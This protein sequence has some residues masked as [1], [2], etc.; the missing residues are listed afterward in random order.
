MVVDFQRKVGPL[1]S[2]GGDGCLWSLVWK[3]IRENPCA[4]FVVEFEVT[5]W[6]MFQFCNVC[7]FFCLN[8]LNLSSIVTLKMEGCNPFRRYVYQPG[9]NWC[10]PRIQNCG[11]LPSRVSLYINTAW[12]IERYT[13]VKAWRCVFAYLLLIL[14]PFWKLLLKMI[15]LFL[16]W[17]MWFSGGYIYWLLIAL[18]VLRISCWKL[19]TNLCDFREPLFNHAAE[20]FR[21]RLGL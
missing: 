14:I 3:R 13:V 6:V 17:D 10:F 8:Y 15:F 1:V 9:L 20:C 19:Q 4:V 5:R 18:F 12:S 7:F 11:R 16:R 2:E 21:T